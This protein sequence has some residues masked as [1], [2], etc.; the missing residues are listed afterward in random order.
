MATYPGNYAVPG[1]IFPG[2]ML[3]GQVV[4][5]SA[6]V[7]TQPA[8]FIITVARQRWSV[9]DGRNS[10][11]GG[12]TLTQPA[13]STEAVQLLVEAIQ[14]GAV[15]NPTGDPVAVA[16]VAMPSSGP[17]PAPAAGSSAWNAATWETDPGPQYWASCM[18]G[19]AGGVVTLAAGGYQVFVKISDGSSGEVPIL[20]GPV[21]LIT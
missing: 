11:G 2:M 13:V 10:H 9:A 20:P 3:P 5:G 12:M 19:P 8:V 1:A 18:V 7:I 4:T 16:F 15:Y 21:L 6:P 14:G 17:A